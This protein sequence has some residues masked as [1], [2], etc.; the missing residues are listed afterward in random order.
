MSTAAFAEEAVLPAFEVTLNGQKIESNNREYPLIVYKDITYFPM[1]YYDCR[2][3]GITTDWNNDT[4]T[5]SIQKENISG[6]YR[7]Y[8]SGVRNPRSWYVMPREI[9]YGEEP[10]LPDEYVAPCGFVITVNGKQIDNYD[11]A[12]PL[13]TFRGVTYFPLTWRF[14]H[15]EFGWEY[16]YTDKDGL[17]INSDNYNTE[18]L[19]LPD[20]AADGTLAVAYDGEY[21]YY[22]GNEN[23]IYRTPV[24]DTSKNE[25]IYTIPNNGKEYVDVNFS[26]QND[27][28]FVSYNNG[29]NARSANN[30]FKIVD[31]KMVETDEGDQV[32]ISAGNI[33]QYDLGEGVTVKTS[34]MGTMPYIDVT[35]IYKGVEHEV[36]QEGIYF[37]V[38]EKDGK[39]E[40]SECFYRV[41]LYYTD[42]SA[43]HT[44]RYLYLNGYNAETGISSL[45]RIHLETG[46]MEELLEDVGE[47]YVYYCNPPMD[48]RVVFWRDGQ[49]F[50]YSGSPIKLSVLMDSPLPMKSAVSNIRLIAA[51]SDIGRDVTLMDFGYI[52]KEP[53][54]VLF[55]TDSSA[56][57]FVQNEMIFVRVVEDLPGSHVH[58]A[59]VDPYCEPYFSADFADTCFYNDR[60]LLYTT[61]GKV[62][63]VNMRRE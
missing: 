11:E 43:P 62:V 15:D 34:D 25:L 30:Y 58:F 33:R 56:T 57:T 21:Y 42:N 24:E 45:Y 46:E 5:L 48:N 12:Y 59:A 13:L 4:F 29:Y 44:K 35:Y 39:P 23:K 6:M 51:L 19:A 47:F 18:I 60:V 36:K 8:L 9:P 50:Q 61:E 37:G 27:K 16:S 40:R 1:T 55:H 38:Y 49:L 7:E 10:V 20:A 2:F 63:K 53:G 3:L 41:N 14:A 17:V 22:K 28:L 26:V 52:G 31:G 54:K 32:K